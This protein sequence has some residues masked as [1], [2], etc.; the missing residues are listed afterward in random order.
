MIVQV[1]CAIKADRHGPE[2]SI[3]QLVRNVRATTAAGLLNA[4]ILETGVVAV[5]LSRQDMRPICDGRSFVPCTEVCICG[6]SVR[7][8]K[9]EFGRRCAGHARNQ[10]LSFAMRGSISMA[11]HLRGCDIVTGVCV[12]GARSVSPCCAASWLSTGL[13][14][15]YRA[16]PV[17]TPQTR[18]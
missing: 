15:S 5:K 12:Q 14:E 16:E 3:M 11:R 4:G 18:Q 17:P 6:G 8:A 1:W 7:D 2:R 10:L 9:S 13:E